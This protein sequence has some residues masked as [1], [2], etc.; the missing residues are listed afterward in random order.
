MI[1]A[2]PDAIDA[3]QA[4]RPHE[5]DGRLVDTKRALPKSVSNRI[6]VSVLI[7]FHRQVSTWQQQGHLTC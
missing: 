5:I 7:C 6:F 2:A 4:A 3:V 1:F